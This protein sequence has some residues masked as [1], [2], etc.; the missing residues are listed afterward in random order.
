[1]ITLLLN[2]L[3]HLKK[4]KMYATMLKHYPETAG[5]LLDQG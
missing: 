2:I 1:M 4:N 5:R 3:H